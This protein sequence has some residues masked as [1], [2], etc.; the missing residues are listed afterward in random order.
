MYI[1]S[2]VD[3]LSPLEKSEEFDVVWKLSPCLQQREAEASFV[4]VI[5]CNGCKI[6][7]MARTDIVTMGVGAGFCMYDVVVKKFT[8]DISSPGEF[9]FLFV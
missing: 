5:V 1:E 8:F 4:F 2:S 9:L 6:H 7:G 3:M